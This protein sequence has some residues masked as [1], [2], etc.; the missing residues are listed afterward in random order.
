MATMRSFSLYDMA[1]FCEKVAIATLKPAGRGPHS[2]SDSSNS[3]LEVLEAEPMDLEPGDRRQDTLRFAFGPEHP[4]YSTHV[5]W[6]HRLKDAKVP[7]YNG[8]KFPNRMAVVR[9]RG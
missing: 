3:D 7:R 8:P 6:V 9:I 5:L 1:C 4:E 2:D